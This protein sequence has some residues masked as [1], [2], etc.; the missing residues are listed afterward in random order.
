MIANCD[1]FVLAVSASDGVEAGTEAV[2]DCVRRWKKPG[3]C[4]I[5]KADR[6]F[7]LESILSQIQSASPT[8]TPVSVQMPYRDHGGEFV[9]IIDLVSGT[10]VRFLRN[11][12]GSIL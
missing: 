2:L 3:V 11:G 4:V 12:T 5:N 9:G 7:S 8:C 1:A 10:A 6:A